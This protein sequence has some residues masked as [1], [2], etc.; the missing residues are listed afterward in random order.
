MREHGGIHR[1]NTHTSREAAIAG[2]PRVI[3]VAASRLTIPSPTIT[4]GFRRGLHAA[5]ASR[6]KTCN[7]K[8]HASGYHETT[9]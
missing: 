8:T 2:E 6:L 5:A 4:H 3:A 7:F 1:R 9:Q